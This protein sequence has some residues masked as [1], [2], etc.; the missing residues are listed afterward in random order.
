MRRAVDENGFDFG[1]LHVQGTGH[2]AAALAQNL[3]DFDR[4]ARERFVERA[5]ACFQPAVDPRDQS[6]EKAG[7]LLGLGRGFGVEC[8]HMCG[9]HMRGFLGALAEL[10]VQGLAT[11]RQHVF[12]GF[13]PICERRREAFGMNTEVV[14]GGAALHGEH[15][16][17]AAKQLGQAFR[18]LLGIGI[19]IGHDAI[20]L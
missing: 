14:D 5:C 7:D 4:A 11:H 17:G 15:F 6:F 16:F 8:I 9:K 20:A 2:F 12:Y 1:C 10:R 13:E 18:E 3:G 19:E